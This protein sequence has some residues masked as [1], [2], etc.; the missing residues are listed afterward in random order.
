[1]S[2]SLTVKEAYIEYGD[3]TI[4]GVR[5][6]KFQ[7]ELFDSL[8]KYNRILLRAPTGSGKTFTLILGAIKSYL[9]RNLYPVVGIY[10]SRAL[11][12]DQ[13]RSV[14]ETLKRMGLVSSGGNSSS[15]GNQSL[16]GAGQGGEEQTTFTGRLN[17]NGKDM[18]EISIKVYILTREVKQIPREFQFPSSPSIV[19]TVPEYP[20]M[21]MTGMNR[22]R[23]ASRVL[24]AAMKYS[25]DDAINELTKRDGG[26]PR[27]D[28]RELLNYFSVFFNGYWF[29]DEFHLYS[30]ISRESMLTLVEMFEKYNSVF[31]GNKTVVFSSATPVPLKF[32]KVI[33]VKTSTEGSKIRGRTKVVFHLVGK[34]PQE[35]L[36]NYV[37]SNP[38]QGQGRKTAVI[39]DRVY[40]LADLCSKVNDAAVVWGI[41]KPF[42]NCRK[43]TAGLEKED[44]I[45]GN[46]AMSFG[47]DLPL[48]L[49]FIHA[50]D[51]ETFIQRFGRFG[52]HGDAEV[53]VFLEADYKV[54]SG[55]KALQN[56]EITY[57][58]FL[59]LVNGIYGK[60]VD[61]G[62]DGIF[63]SKARHDVLIRA[64]SL[65][66]AISNGE[67]VY[68]LVRN[69]YP[70]QVN[71]LT[72]RPSYDDYF[73]VFAYRPGGLTGKW[74][75]GNE[76]DLF[77]LIRNFRYSN[78][79]CFTDEILRESPGIVPR[80]LENVKCSFMHFSEFNESLRPRLVLRR[81]N[82]SVL[83]GGMKEFQDSYVVILTRDC[84]NWENFTEMARLV[85]TY[86]SAIPIYKDD[87]MK[88]AVGLALFI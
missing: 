51:A 74:C 15:S 34:N 42:G 75:D 45:I 73:N 22:Q 19:L 33:E 30:G 2:V 1:M 66:Y 7:E 26:V 21:F 18:G 80:K 55:L 20:Y 67:Q 28:V 39:L 64:F 83:M 70:G 27:S 87:D 9:E 52:R 32:D 54:V 48:E 13:A 86:E 5:L 23:V 17:I 36:V 85:A 50:H 72:I 58:E 8:G 25:F 41:D 6:R 57:D 31:E 37:V 88:V 53:H 68:D 47:I 56:R 11:V 16:Q 46:Q 82:Y 78:N 3:T 14:Q 35:N 77:S 76:D 59:Q 65:I 63:F 43:V 12:Y 62:L 44:F 84:V 71:P 81:Q 24:E 69:W 38:T 61:D 60:R 10:P 49:G 40:Y 4:N 79:Y 29:V